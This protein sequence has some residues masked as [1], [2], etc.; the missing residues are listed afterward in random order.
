[1][2]HHHQHPGS[3]MSSGMQGGAH[4]GPGQEGHIKRCVKKKIDF[5]M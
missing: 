5:L 4:G 3:M 1:M 2:G